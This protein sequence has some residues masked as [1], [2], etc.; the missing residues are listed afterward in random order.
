MVQRLPAAAV[1]LALAIIGEDS[2]AAGARRPRDEFITQTGTYRFHHGNLTLRFYEDKGKLNYERVVSTRR[3]GL[4]FLKYE[5][6]SSG[7]P[8]D[9]WIEKGPNW[10]AFVESPRSR[11]PVAV[12]IFDGRG[13]LVLLKWMPTASD[14]DLSYMTDYD[15]DTFPTVVKSVPKAVLDRLP[16]SF[17][18]KCDVGA[19]RSAAAPAQAVSR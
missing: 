13:K 19:L 3:V 6:Y 8:A 14:P 18:R 11:S 17:L 9:A 10:F 5:E 12:W 15:P 2:Q 7:G 1:L 16:R 4:P